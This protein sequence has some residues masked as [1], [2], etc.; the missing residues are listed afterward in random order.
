MITYKERKRR[1][2]IKN[3]VIF[4]FFTTIVLAIVAGVYIAKNFNLNVSTKYERAEDFCEKYNMNFDSN[5]IMRCVKIQNDTV[6]STKNII[7]IDSLR[8]WSFSR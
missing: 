7:Y 4:V 3:I 6:I 2:F 1:E 8:D 5:F